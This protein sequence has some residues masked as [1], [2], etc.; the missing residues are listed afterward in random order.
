MNAKTMNVLMIVYVVWL[1]MMTIVVQNMFCKFHK[2]KIL[3]LYTQQWKLGKIPLC[4]H[5]S[6]A[7]LV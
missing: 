7:K 4:A 6:Q 2:T 1:C 3:L 5:K